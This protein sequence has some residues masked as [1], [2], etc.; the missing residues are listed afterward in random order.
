MKEII[1]QTNHLKELNN[2]NLIAFKYCDE[3]GN[4]NEKI[5]LMVL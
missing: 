3:K 5:I 4:I 2:E 1:L